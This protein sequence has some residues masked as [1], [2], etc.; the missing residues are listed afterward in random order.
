MRRFGDLLLLCAVAAGSFWS[1]AW[2]EARYPGEVAAYAGGPRVDD[3]SDYSDGV[4]V[5]QAAVGDVVQVIDGDSLWFADGTGQ[6]HEFRLQGIDA[7]EGR[8]A[9]GDAARDHLAELVLGRTVRIDVFGVDDYDRYLGRVW[10]APP[11]C[12][13]CPLDV[14]ANLALV[15]AGMAWWYRQ[16]RKQQSPADREA[17]ERAEREARDQQR[18]LWSQPNPMPPWQWRRQKNPR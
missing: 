7:P 6:R 9:F 10:V 13:T 3:R 4:E 11:G 8:Q 5:G 14:D 2:F 1:G 16:Y 15:D 18:G 12:D 17:Y